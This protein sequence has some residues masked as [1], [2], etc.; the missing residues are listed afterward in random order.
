[1][2]ADKNL[3]QIC[4][5]A[6][7]S[8]ADLLPA[9]LAD[10]PDPDA[11]LNFFERLTEQ[12]TSELFRSLEKHRSLVH[13]SLS[14]FGHSHY[15]GETLLHNSDLLAGLLREHSLDRSHS[16]EEFHEAF[17]RFRS[18][19]FETDMAQLLSRFKRREYVRIVLRDVL[20]LAPLSE[21]TGEISALSDVLIDEALRDC[22]SA[23]HA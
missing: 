16:R 6:P 4:A 2:R 13:Y 14:L 23:L 11:A 19:S 15:L 8:V 12:A 9:L 3:A 17:A 1:E 20:G 7:K 22:E 21:A 18:R 10:V 5:R